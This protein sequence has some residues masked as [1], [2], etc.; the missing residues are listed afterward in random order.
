MARSRHFAHSVLLAF[1]GQA[2]V[3]TAGLWLTPFLL[4]KLGVLRY[5]VWILGQQL[6]TYVAM[7]D[8][9]IVALLPR[10]IAYAQT[11]DAVSSAVA[12]TARLLAVQTPIAG[13]IAIA[14][15]LVLTR[16]AQ[17]GTRSRR[18]RRRRFHRAV[19]VSSRSR[20]L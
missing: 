7:L 20:Y 13:V 4:M 8:F 5:G 1:A 2:I 18:H 17:P 19:S 11:R 12:R 14:L 6:L 16:H 9:G 15:A 10:D 3:M